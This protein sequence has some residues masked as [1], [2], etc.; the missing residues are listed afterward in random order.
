MFNLLIAVL[1]PLFLVFPVQPVLGEKALVM[2]L[3]S[4]AVERRAQVSI[5]EDSIRNPFR[6]RTAPGGGEKGEEL[7]LEGILWNEAIPLAV[8]NSRLVG[9]GDM[10]GKSIVVS[11]SRNG[12]VVSTAGG[13][14]QVL[15]FKAESIPDVPWN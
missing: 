11:I 8:I 14:T 1:F 7:R 9:V 12:V 3:P 4:G 6:W 2:D 5:G 10:V 13:I 15:E